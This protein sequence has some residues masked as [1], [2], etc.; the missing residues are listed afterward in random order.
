M[1]RNCN[2]L[3]V[4]LS[5][6]AKIASSLGLDGIFFVCTFLLP[7]DLDHFS[8]SQESIA[9]A[10]HFNVDSAPKLKKG[11]NIVVEGSCVG[12]NLRACTVLVLAL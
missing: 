10:N 5:F 6:I 11:T 9:N 1:S 2:I 8:V 12:R 4:S 7:W 3:A